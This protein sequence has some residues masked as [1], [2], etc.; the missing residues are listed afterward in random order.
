MQLPFKTVDVFTTTPYIGN[1]LAIIRVPSSLRNILTEEQKQKIAREFNLSETTF[2][3]EPVPGTEDGTADVD[4]FTPISRLAFAG[5]PTIGTA[6]YVSQHPEMYPGIKQLK[7]LAGTIPFTYSEHSGRVSVNVPH[8]F[9]IHR[10]R[11]AH[12]FPGKEDGSGSAT[13]PLVSIV[14][15]MAFNLVSMRD[16]QALGLP[17]KGLLPVEECYK[18]E[19]L[20][21]GS[22][23]DVGYT[24]TFY[25]T[26]L[27]IE[28]GIEGDAGVR[29][30]RTRSIGTREDPGTGSASCALCCY[31]A[32][33]A[34]QS[35]AEQVQK[36]HLTQ[37]VEMGRRCD[38]FIT[39]QTTEDGKG[40]ESVELSGT[41]V[42]VMK[43]SLTID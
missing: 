19:Y 34:R 12:P 8:A 9:R 16:V 17:T 3:H 33:V 11:L 24:G 4:I 32:I 5:H 30:L 1:P 40:I 31:L 39:V 10:S 41:A 7:M 29:K 21:R 36:F 37:G 20:D 18:A 13:V 22:G 35:S 15:G 27:G 26:D 2:L 23:W 38:I 14:K 43:G 25:Y 6:M 28:E 42:I